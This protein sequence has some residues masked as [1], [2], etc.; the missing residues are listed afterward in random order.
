MND[1]NHITILFFAT[2]R[3]LAGSSRLEMDVPKDLTIAGLVELLAR[4]HPDLERFQD[5]MM[6]AV[7][8]KY[9]GREEIIPQEAEVAFF[10]P[11]SGG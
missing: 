2:L 7:N 6:T 8:R 5:S 10:P 4:Q 3:D 11:V 1:M 9:A